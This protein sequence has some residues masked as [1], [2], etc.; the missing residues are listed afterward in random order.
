MDRRFSM[1]KKE[2]SWAMVKECL[3][4]KGIPSTV[5]YDCIAEVCVKKGTGFIKI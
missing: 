3:E 4:K 1:S 2:D 5:V